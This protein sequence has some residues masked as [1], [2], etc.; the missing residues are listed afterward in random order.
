MLGWAKDL[1]G[2]VA[3]AAWDGVTAVADT[4]VDT[5]GATASIVGS[6][7]G[8]VG[9]AVDSATFGAASG[10]LSLV[11]DT[12]L[13]GIDELTGGIVDVD[14]DDGNFTAGVGIDGLAKVD[15]GIGEDGLSHSVGALN[16]GYDLG[17]DA[18]GVRASATA[19]INWG[20][21]PYTDADIAVGADGDLLVDLEAQGTIPTPY[22]LV[23]GST[24]LGVM[25][26]DEGFGLTL[27]TDGTLRRP[28]GSVIRGGVEVGYV[29]TEDGSAL[30]VG[31][32][33]SYSQPGLGTI[34]GSVGYSRVEQGDVVVEG[35]EAEANI[36]ILGASLDAGVEMA[37]VTTEDGTVRQ[38]D[39]DVDAS[40]PE[41]SDLGAVAGAAL[42]DAQTGKLLGQ[43]AEGL[44][45]GETP[46]LAEL[47]A[48]AGSALGDA[49]T[50][51]LLGGLAD[52]LIA[53]DGPDAVAGADISPPATDPLGADVLGTTTAPAAAPAQ[54]TAAPPPAATATTPIEPNGAPV[55]T[56]PGPGALPEIA[57]AAP[58]APPAPDAPPPA[59]AAPAPAPDAF[60]QAIADADASEASVDDLFSDLG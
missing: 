52:G 28:D 49:Q 32:E 53:G 17:V 47:G 50:G 58:A 18:E 57:A 30:Q 12:V 14:F 40:A 27:D 13:D 1:A 56:E 24:D 42:G 5:V 44:I 21:L 51:Q 60:D 10:V 29:E 2:D 20:P 38:W 45:E 33:G 11:D 59:E 39:A 43:V 31:L 46:G 3:G 36:D 6:G 16:Q 25:R 41:L 7:V 4:A 23:S 15:A 19:G 26:N 9:N 48:V 34:G 35:F 22:G 54:P 37:A 8:V 55:P